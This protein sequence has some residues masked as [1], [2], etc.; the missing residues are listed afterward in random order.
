MNFVREYS[1]KNNMP[2]NHLEKA[3]IFECHPIQQNGDC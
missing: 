1:L 2:S 3:I